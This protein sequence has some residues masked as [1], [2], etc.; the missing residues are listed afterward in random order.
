MK[1]GIV[2]VG[3]GNRGIYGAGVLDYCLDHQIDVDYFIGVSAGSANGVSYL[4][5]QRGRNYM[6]YND[7]SF[8]KEYMGIGLFLHTGSLLNLD[9]IYSTLS[10]NDGENPV[11][12]KA[13]MKSS[14]E[15]IIVS[16]DAITGKPVYFQ[17]KDIKENN[18]NFLKAS[19][20]VPI[21]CKPYKINT[22]LYYDG[23]ISDPIPFKKAFEDG[24]DKVI[25]ILT[26][27][28]THFRSPKNDIKLSKFI[29]KKYP[30]AALKLSNRSFIY[31]DSLREALKLEKEGKILIIAPDDISDL[32][33]FTKN[34][35]QLDIL[36][37]KGYKDAEVIRKFIS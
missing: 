17:K 24:C 13:L 33:T 1:I 9:Y 18:Y 29:H 20:C 5:K 7:Y 22:H 37:K 12:Y 6:F 21:A 34:R 28:K 35:K 36:Y 30:E 15:L 31:N 2:D 19:S 25:I 4:S 14:T 16:T 27:P 3:G 8:R 32:D 11:D 23:G 10:N 26:K